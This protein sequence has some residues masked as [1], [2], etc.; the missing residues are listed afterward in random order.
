MFSALNLCGGIFFKSFSY[1][2]EVGAQTFPPIFGLLTI[3]D[4]NFAKIM[5]PPRDRNINY[6]AL[7]K[8]QSTS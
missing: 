7:L 4:R 6:L 3:F 5:A 8:R 2:Y 1:L